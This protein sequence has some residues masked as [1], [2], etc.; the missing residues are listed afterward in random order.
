MVSI[1]EE[2][3]WL[4][5]KGKEQSSKIRLGLGGILLLMK[6]Q[7][8]KDILVNTT[9][10]RVLD[11]RFS[12][13]VSLLF[14]CSPFSFLC[15]SVCLRFP[16]GYWVHTFIFVFGILLVEVSSSQT[17]SCSIFSFSDLFFSRRIASLF[18]FYSMQILSFWVPKLWFLY[19]IHAW[20]FFL[21]Y[22]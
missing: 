17:F 8:W 18:F 4:T 20:I 3:S 22:F 5:K 19:L 15:L 9:Q 14:L 2:Q 12:L 1:I 13:A 21:S 10:S 11:I 7:T 6:A 16:E